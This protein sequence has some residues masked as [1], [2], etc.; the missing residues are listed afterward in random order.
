MYLN[1]FLKYELQHYDQDHFDN[2]YQSKHSLN[3][4]LS[5]SDREIL[6]CNYQKGTGKAL[7]AMWRQRERVKC[8]FDGHNGTACAEYCQ[9]HLLEV[10][11]ECYSSDIPGKWE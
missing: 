3:P 2:S 5:F 4:S 8:R 10:F 7:L 6:W 1:T 9:K 11:L